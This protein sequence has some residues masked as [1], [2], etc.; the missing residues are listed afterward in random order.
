MIGRHPEAV[1]A[2]SEAVG[3]NP[4][5]APIRLNYAVAL[6]AVGR[7]DLGRRQAEEALKLD[8]SYERAKQFLASLKR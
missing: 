6:A 2:F 1:A 5:S 8:P 7:P 4:K 3:R